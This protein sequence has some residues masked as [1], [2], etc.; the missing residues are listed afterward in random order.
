MSDHSR[1]PY[2]P[3]SEPPLA[4][5]GRR[6]RRGGGGPAPVTLIISLLLLAGVGGGVFLMY[7]GGARAP[8]GAPAPVGAPIQDVKIA[9]PPEAPA[10]DPAAGLSIYKDNP[11]AGAAQPAFVPPPE[12][13]TPRPVAG[14]PAAPTATPS[15][16]APSAAQTP[17]AAASLQKPPAAVEKA[18]ANAPTIDRILADNSDVKSP[19]KPLVKPVAKPQA[20]VEAK[21]VAKPATTAD[22]KADPGP[23]II[24]IGA[25]SSKAL[26]DAGWNA[27]AGAAPGGMAGKGKRVVPVTKADGTTLYRTSITGFSSHAEAVALCAKLKAAGESCFVR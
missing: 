23:A 16:A 13:P 10:P 2:T 3:G 24:Q 12:Q 4:F 7:R 19:V 25:F 9:A 5:D 22:A 11:G 21:P 20:V 18:S 26:A 15:V 17:T 6:P 27:A 1:G 8:G 14:Q